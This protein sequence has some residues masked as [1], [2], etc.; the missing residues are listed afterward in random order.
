M[1]TI[2]A[3]L[4]LVSVTAGFA[5]EVKWRSF[6]AGLAE[7]K[8]THKKILLDVYTDWCKWC[9]KLDKEVYTNDKVSKYLAKAYIPV[10]L[11]GEGSTKVTYKSQSTTEMG[12]TQA[13]GIQSYPTIIFLDS[14][15][16][17]INS[18]G[19]FI[20]ADRFLPIITYIGDDHYKS[21][22]WQ[23]YKTKNGLDVK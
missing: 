17:P 8:K 22:S 20:D 15:G 21:I 3:L 5:G 6:D 4:L 13:F 2:L 18:L 12:L 23:D 1:K 10:K 7:A 9:T 11:N 16:E 14:E 19:G